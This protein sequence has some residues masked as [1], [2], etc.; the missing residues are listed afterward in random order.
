[1][2]E[3]HDWRLQISLSGPAEV[4]SEVLYWLQQAYNQNI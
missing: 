1:M 3:T 2:V 4:D